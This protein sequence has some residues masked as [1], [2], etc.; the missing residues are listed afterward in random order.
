MTV[1]FGDTGDTQMTGAASGLKEI[2]DRKRVEMNLE[3][4][5]DIEAGSQEGAVSP[6]EPAPAEAAPAAPEGAPAE[7]PPATPA[8]AAPA[9]ESPAP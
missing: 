2:V 7:V 5:Q 4:A 6:A 3:A 1:A 9:A 8:P